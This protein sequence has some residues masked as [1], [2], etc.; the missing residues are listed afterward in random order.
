VTATLPF[1]DDAAFP[2]VLRQRSVPSVRTLD[3]LV[4]WLVERR[5]ALWDATLRGL[6]IVLRGFPILEP[7][8]FERVAQALDPLVTPYVGAATDRK[9][10]TDATYVATE[11]PPRFHL[12]LHSET[13]YL[14]RYPHRVFFFCPQPATRGG[15]TILG[16]NR[17]LLA[18]VED[19]ARERFRRRGVLYVRNVPVFPRWKLALL[20][21]TKSSAIKTWQEMFLTEDRAGVEAWYREH[22]MAMRWRDDGGLCLNDV[23]PATRL[24]PRTGEEVWFNQGHIFHVNARKFGWTVWAAQRLV[25]GR[26]LDA[27]YDCRYGDGEVVPPRDMLPIYDVM[28]RISVPIEWE[29]GDVV[30]IDNLLCSHGRMPFRGPRRVLY[31]QAIDPAHR[32]AAGGGFVEPARASS[33]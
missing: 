33:S 1:D 30:A 26:G 18:E 27:L 28:D 32:A 11:S 5:A 15:A 12:P 9:A 20:K 21:S 19:G 7:V 3:D 4:A 13:C 25:N 14:R 23:L 2:L 24:H 16:D 17:R 8:D 31:A 29:K 6:A 10:V 22:D